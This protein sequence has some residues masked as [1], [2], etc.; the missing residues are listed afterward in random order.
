[1]AMWPAAIYR[2]R[3]HAALGLA[4]AVAAAAAAIAFLGRSDALPRF[5]DAENATLVARGGQIYAQHCARCHGGHL[6]GQPH[7]QIADATGRVPAPPQDAT[8]HSWQHSDAEIF[9]DIKYSVTDEAPPGY[10]TDM[11]AFIDVLTDGDIFA[12]IAFIKRSWPL[13]VRAS[14]AMLNPGYAGLPP[15]ADQVEWRL[16]PTCRATLRRKGLLR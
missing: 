12:V 2:K 8:G 1:M 14:Q 3:V 10:V 11:P 5:A 16:P 6:E 15:G 13:G 4:G 7:W 9:H